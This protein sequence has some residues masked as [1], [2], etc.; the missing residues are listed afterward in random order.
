MPAAAR[1]RG[2]CVA[3][4]AL[5]AVAGLVEGATA[6]AEPPPDQVIGSVTIDGSNAPAGASITAFQG[7]AFCGSADY[8]GTRFTLVL[9]TQGPCAVPGAV[10]AFQVNGRAAAETLRSPALWGLDLYLNLTVGGPPA[11][12]APVLQPGPAP[13]SVTIGG[14]AASSTPGPSGTAS[15]A[16]TPAAQ[17]PGQQQTATPTPAQA[18]PSQTPAS[19]PAPSSTSAPTPGSGSALWTPQTLLADRASWSA[20]ALPPAQVPA[21]LA[22]AITAYAA[23]HQLSGYAGDCHTASGGAPCSYVFRQP[24]GNVLVVFPAQPGAPVLVASFTLSGSTWAAAG[25]VSCRGPDTTGN[26]ACM[27]TA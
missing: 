13:T 7:I 25:A 5:L 23:A 3:L 6:R 22:S 24:N 4:G 17:G 26:V 21:A 15:A 10:I 12:A 14:P 27:P 9:S 18:T 11:S 16:N 8:D 2:M 19:T 1:R 20:D